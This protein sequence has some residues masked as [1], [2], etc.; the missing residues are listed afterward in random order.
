MK[1][2]GPFWIESKP[3]EGSLA[4]TILYN[5]FAS[6][7]GKEMDYECP[8]HAAELMNVL[9]TPQDVEMIGD[10]DP[11]SLFATIGTMSWRSMPDYLQEPLADLNV[12]G[13]D[14]IVAIRHWVLKGDELYPVVVGENEE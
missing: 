4:G 9:L 6:F 1:I 11:S 3:S 13:E 10:T 14:T 2:K 8:H 5:Q 7:S 12:F